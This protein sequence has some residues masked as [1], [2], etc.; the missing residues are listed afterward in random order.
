[1]RT[2]EKGKIEKWK[3]E[4]LGIYWKVFFHN[5]FDIKEKIE[6]N[7]KSFRYQ[8]TILTFIM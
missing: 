2:K 5:L 8:I 7:D 4:K 6:W 3:D 1:M